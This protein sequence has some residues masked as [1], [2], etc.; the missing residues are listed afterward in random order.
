MTPVGT[1]HLKRLQQIGEVRSPIFTSLSKN[2]SQGKN[3]I[4][5]EEV[6][7]ESDRLL[8]ENN[9]FP[10]PNLNIYKNLF[11]NENLSLMMD[12]MSKINLMI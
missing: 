2:I 7:I 5:L 4:K 10:V 9:A 11:E 12:L 8:S 6:D 1:Y 3:S